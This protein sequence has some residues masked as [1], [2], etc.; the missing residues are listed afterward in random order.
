M[1]PNLKLIENIAEN[2]ENEKWGAVV[3]DIGLI[4][5]PQGYLREILEC[6]RNDD[7][8]FSPDSEESE[9]WIKSVG[10]MLAGEYASGNL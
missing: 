10:P 8:E 4:D 3:D 6:L 2:I 1:K 7:G 5:R 9:R